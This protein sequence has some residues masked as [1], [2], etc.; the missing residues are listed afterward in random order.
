M[1]RIM[2]TGAATAALLVLG[3][4]TPAADAQPSPVSAAQNPQVAR[5]EQAY[6]LACAFCHGNNLE[7]GEGPALI[8]G[9]RMAPYVNAARLYQYTRGTMPLDAPGSL[10]EQQYYDLVA[11]LLARNNL[12]ADNLT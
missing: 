4:V 12:L 3:G 8:G 11:Y 5:G 10:S 9:G 7:G 1:K 2:L 6:S